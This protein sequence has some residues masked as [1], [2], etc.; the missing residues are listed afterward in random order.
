VKGSDLIAFRAREL[1]LEEVRA[2]VQVGEF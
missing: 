2:R 1:T